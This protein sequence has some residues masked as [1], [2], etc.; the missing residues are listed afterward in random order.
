MEIPFAGS[1]GIVPAVARA[2]RL[3]DK[4]RHSRHIQEEPIRYFEM[5]GKLKPGG[6]N[7]LAAVTP[8]IERYEV[9][10]TSYHFH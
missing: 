4:P 2:S 5:V 3:A 10:R 1:A 8:K 9:H 7:S 6:R